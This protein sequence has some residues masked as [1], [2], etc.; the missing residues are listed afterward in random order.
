MKLNF[1]NPA[2]WL[3]TLT[4]LVVMS[5]GVAPSVAA[6]A[7]VASVT[8]AGGVTTPYADF[9]AALLAAQESNGSTLKL[10]SEA[11]MSGTQTITKG[12][13]TIDMNGNTLK[14]QNAAG[15][16]LENCQVT[17]TDT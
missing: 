16:V 9:L 17:F 3:L 6:A 4:L 10:L 1:R 7:D 8:T 15:L 2:A 12:S 5:F 14:N 13:F 11:K